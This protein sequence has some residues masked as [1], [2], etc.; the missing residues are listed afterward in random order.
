ML[1]VGHHQAKPDNRQ[2]TCPWFRMAHEKRN[3]SWF[4]KEIVKTWNQLYQ[5]NYDSLKMLAFTSISLSQMHMP[6]DLGNPLW[7]SGHRQSA[8][9]RMHLLI[10]LHRMLQSLFC[11]PFRWY[12]WEGKR[13][14]ISPVVSSF[15]VAVSFTPC[16][17]YCMRIFYVGPTLSFALCARLP[18]WKL[19]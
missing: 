6:Y 10:C 18:R 13:K 5:D 2:S 17:I 15:L 14:K 11:R 1:P 9:R 19:I 8:N 7:T 4:N 16:Y 12:N 3:F